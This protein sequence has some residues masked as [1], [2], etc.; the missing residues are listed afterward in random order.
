MMLESIKLNEEERELQECWSTSDED[1]EGFDKS[2]S[3]LRTNRR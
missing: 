2:H 3:R 1:R